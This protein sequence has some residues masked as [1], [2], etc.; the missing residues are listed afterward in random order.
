MTRVKTIDPEYMF[1]ISRE[2]VS[3]LSV[4]HWSVLLRLLRPTNAVDK[5]HYHIACHRLRI[6]R[7]GCFGITILCLSLGQAVSFS[8]SMSL[9]LRSDISW[10][11]LGAVGNSW[12]GSVASAGRIV[13]WGWMTRDC[14]LVPSTGSLVWT[15]TSGLDLSVFPRRVGSWAAWFS[16]EDE[17]EGTLFRR[18]RA[19]CWIAKFCG[20]IARW[21]YGSWKRRR[22]WRYG[23]GRIHDDSQATF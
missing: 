16:S 19:A 9:R 14:V 15:G 7:Y 10:P 6:I 20:L 8:D 21:S 12:G 23:R 4:L 1:S 3:E 22:A 18:S 13:C 11:W 5:R 17:S 2:F